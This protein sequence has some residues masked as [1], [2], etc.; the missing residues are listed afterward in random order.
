LV[1]LGIVQV[2][3]CGADDI[4]LS[5]FVAMSIT[6]SEKVQRHVVQNCPKID[7][8]HIFIGAAE[9]P[10]IFS[11]FRG[12]ADAITTISERIQRSHASLA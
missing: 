9:W 10:F 8:F 2:N 12:I 4:S 11:Q 7:A 6:G 1:Q 3:F 5:G